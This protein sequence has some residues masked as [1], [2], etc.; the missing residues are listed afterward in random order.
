M[1]IIFE[2]STGISR[3]KYALDITRYVLHGSILSTPNLLPFHGSRGRV[4]IPERASRLPARVKP[5]TAREGRRERM[6]HLETR[7][8][9]PRINLERERERTKFLLTMATLKARCLRDW[10][11]FAVRSHDASS[12]SWFR[13][14]PRQPCCTAPPESPQFPEAL[15]KPTV[16]TAEFKTP[17]ASRPHRVGPL[18]RVS[19]TRY[20]AVDKKRA[21][22]VRI[23]AAKVNSVSGS[24]FKRATDGSPRVSRARTCVRVFARFIA[25]HCRKKSAPGA[26]KPYHTASIKRLRSCV[27]LFFS[28][29]FFFFRFNDNDRAAV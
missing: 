17:E 25:R 23:D 18:V 9:Q 2:Y 21:A 5:S 15:N 22:S 7:C 4:P 13:D 24:T 8:K 20:D 11:W 14:D 12:S 29:R 6:P 1:N 28:C 27:A 16:E 10:R 19:R 3:R 26:P